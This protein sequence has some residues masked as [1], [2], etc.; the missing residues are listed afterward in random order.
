[1]LE[2]QKNEVSVKRCGSGACKRLTRHRPPMQTSRR[3][4]RHGV[5][6]TTMSRSIT[7]KRRPR[8]RQCSWH[9]VA[10][11]HNVQH[12]TPHQHARTTRCTGTTLHV[13]QHLLVTSPNI[14]YAEGE[15]TSPTMW[16]RYDRHFVGITCADFRAKICRAIHMNQISLSKYL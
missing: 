9:G 16:S 2:F 13:C 5:P 11:T 7:E 8:G 12:T 4:G 3:P 1:V 15:V 10:V 6:S 14:L